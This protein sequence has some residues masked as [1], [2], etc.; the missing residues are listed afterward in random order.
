MPEQRMPRWSDADLERTADPVTREAINWFTLMQDERLARDHQASFSRWRAA[1]PAHERAFREVEQLW[2]GLASLRRRPAGGLSRRRVLGGLAVVGA[3]G[4]AG[5]AYNHLAPAGI[6]T[7]K[8]ELRMIEL[9][10]RGRIELSASTGI[11]VDLAGPV[12]SARLHYGQAYFDLRADA[13]RPFAVAT[14]LGEVRSSGA[15][16]DLAD[17]GDD[18]R[19][20]VLRQSAEVR[21]RGAPVRVDGGMQVDFGAWGV[22]RPLVV[23]PLQATA[24]REGRLVFVNARLDRIVASLNRWRG[25]RIVVIGGALAGRTAT[26][27]VNV[28]DIDDALDHLRDALGLSVRR[29]TPLLTVLS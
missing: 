9:A 17:E 19:L 27:I 2:G 22:G 11:S 8:G 1:D 7:G 13:A 4:G 20:T 10:G 14:R 6:T 15:G 16:F 21:A 3:A 12:G 23:D 26:L 29:F 18:I 25:G 24:W 5:L 28:A